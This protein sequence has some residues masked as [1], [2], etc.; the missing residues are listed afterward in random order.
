MRVDDKHVM[1]YSRS[2][3]IQSGE[4]GDEDEGK[5]YLRVRRNIPPEYIGEEAFRPCT[6]CGRKVTERRSIRFCVTTPIP[7]LMENV[8]SAIPWNCPCVEYISFEDMRVFATLCLEACLK[9]S[10]FYD[11]DEI[12]AFV[13]CHGKFI[14]KAAFEAA[15]LRHGRDKETLWVIALYENWCTSV[16]GSGD[17]I[18]G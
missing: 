12:E 6:E 15:I 4:V 3:C 1:W 7:A 9:R 16:T 5:E 8:T 14:Y 13:N 11:R 2:V 10:N 17:Y 18:K